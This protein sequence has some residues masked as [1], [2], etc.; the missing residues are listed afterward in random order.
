LFTEEEKLDKQSYLPAYAQLAQ[1]LRQRISNETYTPGSRLPSEASLAKNFGV[2]TM[3][4]R[5]A[6]GVLVEEGLLRRVQ[7]SGTF[8]RRLQIAT[9]QFG[10]DS[11]RNILVD[12]E[13]LEVRILKAAVEAASQTQQK[14]LDLHPQDPVIVVERLIIHQAKPFTFQVGYARFD[15]ESP[16]VETMLDTEVLTGL[17]FEGGG[18]SFMKGELKLLPTSFDAKEA[19]ILGTQP[20]QNAFKLEHI[21]YDFTNRPAAFGWFIV[22]PERMP[23]ITRVGVWNE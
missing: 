22:S 9:S 1:I 13:N 11:L 18:S 20:G 2:S 15:P 17:F 5:Q 21:F 16:I 4:A 6:V 7:G 19:D 3:T 8:V 14:A 12:R 23:L 10:L